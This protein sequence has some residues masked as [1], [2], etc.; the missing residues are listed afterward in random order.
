MEMVSFP[1]HFFPF[2][3]VSSR[4]DLF[5]VWR[6]N[7]FTTTT[8]SKRQKKKKE[9]QRFV[10]QMYHAC[11]TRIFEP[12]R[13]G[14]TKPE[15]VRCP[16]RHLRRAVYSIGPVIADYPEQVWLSGIVQGWC[17]KYVLFSFT[18]SLALIP[19]VD[20]KVHGPSE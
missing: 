1:S 13:S 4:T 5:T 9:Y 20:L 2:P 19:L 8:A 12:L 10:R 3:K 15:V 16:D 7:D 14:M 6:A 17:P 18:T 11:I